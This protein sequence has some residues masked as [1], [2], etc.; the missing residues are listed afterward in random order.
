MNQKYVKA[1]VELAIDFLQTIKDG[2]EQNFV[3]DNPDTY[4]ARMANLT[5]SSLSVLSAHLTNIC[6][7]VSA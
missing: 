6:E 5:I 3:T 2:M 7:E 4:M 1:Q